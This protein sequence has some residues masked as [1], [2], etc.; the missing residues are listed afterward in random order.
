MSSR[1]EDLT[2]IRSPEYVLPKC[3]GC[4]YETFSRQLKDALLSIG[5]SLLGYWRIQSN[6]RSICKF[7]SVL[8][9]SYS[10]KV[11]KKIKILK[12]SHTT[13]RHANINALIKEQPKVDKLDFSNPSLNR[14][15]VR[16]TVAPQGGW[17][18]TNS[19]A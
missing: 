7:F 11:L 1:F 13:I 2:S 3:L 14:F 10:Q 4:L 9:D 16:P 8:K 6:D 15:C 12:Q 17:A 18:I 19:I 5:V